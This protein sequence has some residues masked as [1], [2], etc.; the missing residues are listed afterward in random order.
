MHGKDCQE[1]RLICRR[2]KDCKALQ[3][4]SEENVPFLVGMEEDKYEELVQTCQPFEAEFPGMLR[5][6][7]TLAHGLR[8]LHQFSLSSEE[9]DME[10][11]LGCLLPNMTGG[12]WKFEEPNLGSLIMQSLADWNSVQAEVA[13]SHPGDDEQEQREQ[14]LLE[15][16]TAECS[17]VLEDTLPHMV[18][19]QWQSTSSRA[20]WPYR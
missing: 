20:T 16:A 11:F 10:S 6:K 18:G 13:A 4:I 12:M 5:S 19:V 1:Y 15:K 2:L 7:I 3:T 14:A 8:A 17:A 9:S